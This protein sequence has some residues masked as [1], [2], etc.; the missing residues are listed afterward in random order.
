MTTENTYTENNDATTVTDETEVKNAAAVL[1][2]NRQLLAINAELTAKIAELE[3]QLAQA[4]EAAG[5]AAQERDQAAFTFYAEKPVKAAIQKLGSPA[6]VA[7]EAA[8]LQLCEVRL[9]ENNEPYLVD[10][11]TGKDVTIKELI[12]NPMDKRIPGSR[13][14]LPKS[15]PKPKEEHRRVNPGDP[16]SL[17]RWICDNGSKQ[18]PGV[19]NPYNLLPRAQGA[20][21]TGSGTSSGTPYGMGPKPADKPAAPSPQFGLR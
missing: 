1:T 8:I 11:A 18:Y 19:D 20:G 3:G 12:Y 17:A 6:P 16:E 14:P 15:L 7:M 10:R 9:D 2:K 4:Q 21:A 13:E 5:T